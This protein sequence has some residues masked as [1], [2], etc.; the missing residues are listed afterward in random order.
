[1]SADCDNAPVQV[2]RKYYKKQ[3]ML[4]FVVLEMNIV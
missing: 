1:M 4:E 3:P 2:V